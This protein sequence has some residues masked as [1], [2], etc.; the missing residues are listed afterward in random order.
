MYMEERAMVDVDT[1]ASSQNGKVG[2]NR[3]RK[4]ITL[5]MTFALKREWS[6]IPGWWG[7]TPNFTVSYTCACVPTLV[8]YFLTPARP[9]EF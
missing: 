1:H 7:Y 8:S 4:V 3:N 2:V 9:S 6:F 5:Y